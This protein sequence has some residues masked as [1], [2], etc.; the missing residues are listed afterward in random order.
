MGDASGEA[1]R[2]RSKLRL[3]EKRMRIADEKLVRL[4][5]VETTVD[6]MRKRVEN[7]EA[8]ERRPA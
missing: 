7:L 8:A 6:D 2:L 5:S 4:D 3:L 1:I